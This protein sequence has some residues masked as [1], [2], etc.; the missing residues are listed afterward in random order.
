MRCPAEAC[1][2]SM[3]I[4][5]G[6]CLS[7]SDWSR[8]DRRLPISEELPFRLQH[9]R[10]ESNAGR[11]HPCVHGREL[12]QMPSV[13]VGTGFYSRVFGHGQLLLSAMSPETSGFRGKCG[14]RRPERSP[15]TSKS[16]ISLQLL[17]VEHPFGHGLKEIAQLVEYCGLSAYRVPD[18]GAW[19]WTSAPTHAELSRV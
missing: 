10:G 11:S 15:P 3:P 12:E 19:G 1:R 18:R 2:V 14:I 6:Q 7:T 5:P 16:F 4:R 9:W 8:Q 17:S 13:N